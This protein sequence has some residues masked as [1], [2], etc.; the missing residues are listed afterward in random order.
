MSNRV[1]RL[2]GRSRSRRSRSRRVLRSRI[3]TPS[4]APPGAR[5]RRS[6]G[7]Q[8]D[9]H[10]RD[11]MRHRSRSRSRRRQISGRISRVLRHELHN[12]GLNPDAQG[13]V[14]LAALAR[15]R[16]IAK[17]VLTDAEFNEAAA[18]TRYEIQTRDGVD[19]IRARQGHAAGAVVDE[20]AFTPIT[21]ADL[22]N[23]PRLIAHGTRRKAERSIMQRGLRPG[24]G[25]TDRA[26]I[27]FAGDFS[28]IKAGSSLVIWVN[29]HEL[30]ARGVP[31]Y[32]ASSGAYLT[33]AILFAED[34]W[35]VRRRPW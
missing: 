10:E 17:L 21:A 13:Y 26:H 25:R 35:A 4:R 29:L 15:C 12:H 34:F 24:G 9:R 33:S 18:G 2:R 31:F 23:H 5:E 7:V 6:D 30:V 27:H 16:P 32:R 8:S 20:S 19:Y 28:L 14:R 3:R 11:G 22:H 1:L